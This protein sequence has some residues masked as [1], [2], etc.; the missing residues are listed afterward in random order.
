MFNHKASLSFRRATKTTLTGAFG[1][2]LLDWTGATPAQ[3]QGAPLTVNGIN[4]SIGAKQAS[5]DALKADLTSTPWWGDSSLAAAFATAWR[6]CGDKCWNATA[7]FSRG[8]F[9]SYK[10]SDTT[11]TINQYW[12]AK[13]SGAI[14]NGGADNWDR[15]YVYAYAFTLSPISNAGNISGGS[16]NNKTSNLGATLSPAFKGGTL[17]VDTQTITQS[18]TLDASVTNAIDADGNS[19]TFSGVFSNEVPAVA[20]GITF[21]NSQPNTQSL[22]TLSAASTYTGATTVNSGAL[23]VNGRITSNTTVKPG[24]ILQGT[25]T[26]DGDVI[27]EG[28]VSPGNSIGTL[29]AR[30]FAQRPGATL[31]IEV[32]G[33]D[34]DLLNI[35]GAVSDLSGKVAI[36]GNPTPGK[37][38]TGI[39]APVPYTGNSTAIADTGQ[40]IVT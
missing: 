4:Y 39:T 23:A 20:G 15:T 18:F 8:S 16:G 17:T 32:N 26:I 37:V 35:T 9:F 27:N 14:L 6:D 30:N 40:A 29:T 2:S 5:F 33:S 31:L 21:Q 11:N 24:A 22:I 28:T 34:S 1:L 19:A 13:Q 25:G 3:G 12:Y 10:L 7:A 38:Y 36:A